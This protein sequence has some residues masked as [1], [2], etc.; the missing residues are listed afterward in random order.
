LF[1]LLS[2]ALALGSIAVAQQSLPDISASGSLSPH[3]VGKNKA[4]KFSVAIKN[5]SDPKNVNAIAQSVRVI[6]LPPEGYELEKICVYPAL[7]PTSDPCHSYPAPSPSGQCCS[8]CAPPA[9]AQNI[10]WGSLEPG[11]SISVQGTLV[12]CTPHK[13]SAITVNVVWDAPIPGAAIAVNLGDSQVLTWYQAEWLSNSIKILAVPA[14]LA[15]IT[16]S[17]NL[18]ASQKEAREAAR[19]AER[20]KAQAAADREASIRS[21]TWKQILPVSHNYALKY[22]VPLSWAAARFADELPG[23]KPELAFFYLLLAGKRMTITRNEV[24]GFYFKDLRGEGLAAIC[25]KDQRDLL[26]GEDENPRNLA[27]RAASELL[28]PTETYQSFQE[29]FKSKTAG[30]SPAFNNT[31]IQEAWERF[32]DWLKNSGEGP[33]V[34]RYL[35]AFYAILDYETNRPYEYWYDPPARLQVDKSIEALL[36]EV[37]KHIGFTEREMQD[38]FDSALQVRQPA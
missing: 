38:Y 13:A 28:E 18:L 27:V 8:P 14:L 26:L 7:P 36:R 1:R 24:G 34:V 15:L 12:A 32:Q 5:K 3:V 10:V 4:V 21:E 6:G 30:A 11:E 29:K 20:D 23:P 19:Q 17:L 37:G 25:W 2:V 31:E 22:Y 33:E 16:F 9:G 35:K